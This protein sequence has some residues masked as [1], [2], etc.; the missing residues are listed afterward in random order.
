MIFENFSR[1]YFFAK[2]VSSDFTVVDKASIVG[3]GVTSVISYLAD[4]DWVSV[5]SALAMIFIIFVNVY[6]KF[7]KNKLEQEQAELLLK[8]KIRL[9]NIKVEHQIEMLKEQLRREKANS[10]HY[11]KTLNNV[12]FEKLEDDEDK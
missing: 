4:V 1:I 8:E 7:K 2:G 6:Y 11:I 3:C 10:E 9:S 5:S 12:M